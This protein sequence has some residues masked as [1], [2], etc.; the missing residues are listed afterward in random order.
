MIGEPL[1]EVLLGTSQIVL[2]LRIEQRQPIDILS[3]LTLLVVPLADLL[4]RPLAD[5]LSQI[6]SQEVGS[7]LYEVESPQL[8]VRMLRHLH[9]V[10]HVSQV[11]LRVTESQRAPQLL[12]L[13]AVGLYLRL[14]ALFVELSQT[15]VHHLLVAHIVRIGDHLHVASSSVVVA[16]ITFLDALW[17]GENPVEE[18]REPSL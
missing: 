13:T 3:Q 9:H 6:G 1:H 17:T 15:L 7:L 12:W 4:I 5:V 14:D 16:L 8:V 11:V 10:D 18:C 2:A